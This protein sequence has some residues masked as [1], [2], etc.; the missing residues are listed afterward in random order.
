MGE[1][2]TSETSCVNDPVIVYESEYDMQNS[3][4]Q[5]IKETN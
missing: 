2:R 3:T 5:L 4:D 1:D